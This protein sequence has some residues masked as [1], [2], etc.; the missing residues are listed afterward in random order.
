MHKSSYL[1]MEFLVKYYEKYYSGVRNTSK[2]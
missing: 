1:R 2:F